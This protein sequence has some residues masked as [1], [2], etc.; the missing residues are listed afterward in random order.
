MQTELNC[1]FCKIIKGEEKAFIIAENKGA[2]AIL[3]KF[4][5]SDGHTLLITKKHFPYIAEVDEERLFEFNFE[6]KVDGYSS[7]LKSEP[8]PDYVKERIKGEIEKIKKNF[9]GGSTKENREEYVEQAIPENSNLKEIKQAL[10]K[11]HFG[12]EKVKKAIIRYLAAKKQAGKNLGKV[13]CLVGPAGTGKTTIAESIAEA[14]G[15]PFDRISLGGVHDEGEIRGHRSTYVSAKPG[16]IVRSC[17]KTKVKNPVISV[18][19]I[20]KM[21]KSEQHGDPAAAFLEILDPEQNEKFSDHYIELP[22]DL[23][24]ILFICTANRT[25][26]IP[27]PLRDRMEIIEIPPYT[28]N[29]KQVIVKEHLIPKLLKRYNLTKEQ[30]NFEDSA[31]QEIINHYTW[32]PGI[33]DLERKLTDIISG[34]SEKKIQGELKD[35]NITST[36][37]KEYLGK[38]NVPDLD[39][40]VDYN[41]FGVVKGLSVYNPEIGGGSILP[42]QAAYSSGDGKVII[43]GNLKETMEQSANLALNHI[44]FNRD[45]LGIPATFDFKTNDIY[46][47]ALQASIPK[48]GPSAGITFTTAIISAITNK[49][50]PKG[51]AM[52]GEISLLGEV[53]EIGGVV[54]KINV[55]HRRGLKKVFI[56]QKNHDKDYDDIPDEIKNDN[57]FKISGVKN[58]Q[59]IYDDLFI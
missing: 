18:D 57:N 16:I 4:S 34:F 5:E 27:G 45:K 52:T 22:V 38:P 21:G 31:I 35:E 30:L 26:T 8:F 7:R 19:E 56:P 36:K 50:V 14:L 47:H 44:K 17:Q 1:L 15:R 43:T 20:D 46:I 2:T 25:D 37:V 51:I 49:V 28:R 39:T 12:M 32:E 11:K 42:I 6:S 10:D 23:S 48:D 29:D 58:Y 33:R 41:K 13:I 55:A 59:E 3:D 9:L 24:Q 54:E 40:E 53:L